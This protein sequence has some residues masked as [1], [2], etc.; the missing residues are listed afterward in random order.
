MTKVDQNDRKT[1]VCDRCKAEQSWGI[2]NYKLVDLCLDCYHWVTEKVCQKE[3]AECAGCEG[4][5]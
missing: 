1:Y 3:M 4:C 2:I 5:K